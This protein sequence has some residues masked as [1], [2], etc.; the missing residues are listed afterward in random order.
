MRIS[1]G[2]AMRRASLAAVRCPFILASTL[3]LAACSGQAGES[4]TTPGAAPPAAPVAQS[5]PVVQNGEGHLFCDIS[6]TH[7]GR[8]SLQ[9]VSG[10]G[11]EFEAAVSPIVDGTVQ[12]RGPEKGGAYRFTSHLVG[13]GKGTLAGVGPVTVDELETKVNVEMNRYAQP[14]GAGTALTFSSADMAHRGIYIEF[15]GTAH[16]SN[17]DCY[18][19]RITLG[20]PGPES[21]GK[22]TPGGPGANEPIMAKM[23]VVQ[24]PTTTVVTTTTVTAVRKLP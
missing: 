1:C 20:Q 13:T 15:A 19:F 24:A 10:A 3:A 12:T 21:G 16:G 22:V 9:M 7:N 18:A 5:V 8:Q 23:V 14:G 2:T 4:P 11:L 6:S 17:G